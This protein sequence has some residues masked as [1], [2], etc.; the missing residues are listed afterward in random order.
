MIRVAILT[1]SDS[2]AAGRFEDTSGPTIAQMLDDTLYEICDTGILPDDAQAIA[3]EMKML[4]DVRPL[5]TTTD[6]KKML[7]GGLGSVTD[8]GAL[9]M[10][11]NA[12]TYTLMTRCWFGMPSSYR[13]CLGLRKSRACSSV[14]VQSG[15]L[16]WIG[17]SS[18]S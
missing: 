4:A 7:L 6:F 8:G 10:A 13:G 16:M 2:C 17:P 12:G 3:H 5:A 14:I 11:A 18:S 15:R 9:E 1:I